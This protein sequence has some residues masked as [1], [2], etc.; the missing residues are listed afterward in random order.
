MTGGVGGWQQKGSRQGMRH[1]V[2]LRAQPPAGAGRLAKQSTL[3]RRRSAVSPPVDN[4]F[5]TEQ[6]WLCVA[7]A[8]QAH[9]RM[10]VQAA[11]QQAGRQTVQ[12]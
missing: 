11:A 7:G 6:E 5:I 12:V 2:A 10:C 9:M 4:N 8:H 3:V 1:R